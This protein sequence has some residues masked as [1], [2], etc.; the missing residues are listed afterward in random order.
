MKKNLKLQR[1]ESLLKELLP[2][3]LANFE[4]NRI[5]SLLVTDVICTKGKY[6]AIVYISPEFISESEQ[7]EVLKQLQKAKHTIKSHILNATG[8]FR[9]PEFSFKFDENIDKVNKME[10]LFKKIKA[11]SEQS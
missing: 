5:N 1:V 11:E 4:D 6:D 3:A 10:E 2:E 9:C 7:R 8:W